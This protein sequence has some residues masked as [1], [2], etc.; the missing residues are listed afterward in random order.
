MADALLQSYNT[1]EEIESAI[2]HRGP[3]VLIDSAFSYDRYAEGK[4]YF[5]SNSREFVG[6]FHESPILPGIYLIEGMAQT[7]A[8]C[9]IDG[10]K[11]EFK[12]LAINKVRFK[13]PILPDTTLSY[14]VSVVSLGVF[15]CVAKVDG[16]IVASMELITA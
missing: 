13:K 8:F 2:P 12:I 16:C 14:E 9:R 3:A 10:F 7:A 4:K 5:S 6:H 1:L 15:S 11:S